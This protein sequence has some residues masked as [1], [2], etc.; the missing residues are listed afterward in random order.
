M[1]G[2]V[3]GSGDVGNSPEKRD[4]RAQDARVIVWEGAATASLSHSC[5]WRKILRDFSPFLSLWLIIAEDSGLN[6]KLHSQSS[7]CPDLWRQGAVRGKAA[8]V[9]RTMHPG[10]WHSE[11][12]RHSDIDF[13]ASCTEEVSIISNQHGQGRRLRGGRDSCSCC[14]NS[15]D[16]LHGH[17]FLTT[18][19]RHYEVPSESA[20][21]YRD[22]AF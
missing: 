20:D 5:S 11:I 15:F 8:W 21:F 12:S 10:N 9:C 22:F 18:S 7:K 16:P 13:Q 2:S 14:P 17:T 1:G 19:G 6:Y 4:M 3:R